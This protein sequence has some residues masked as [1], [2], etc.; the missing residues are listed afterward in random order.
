GMFSALY[1]FSMP[2][3]GLMSPIVPDAFRNFLPGAAASRNTVN[4]TSTIA[5]PRVLFLFVILVEYANAMLL[6]TKSVISSRTLC[7]CG[8]GCVLIL[9]SLILGNYIM[10]F[11]IF[12]SSRLVLR[13]LS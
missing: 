3:I 11:F 9:I 10:I 8:F 2:D 7:V 13:Y 1:I 6:T 4:A 5:G 12:S